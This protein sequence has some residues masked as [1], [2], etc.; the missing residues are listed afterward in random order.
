MKYELFNIRSKN[1]YDRYYPILK[2][3]WEEKEGWR[4]INPEFLSSRGIIVKDNND[5]VCAA[6]LYKTD[7]AYGVIN[8]VITNDKIK[9]KQKKECLKYMFNILEKYAK[10]IKISAIYM[11]METGSLKNFLQKEGFLKT[12]DNIAEFFKYI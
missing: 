10:H 3:W 4:S 1:D 7:S 9:A 2:S 6:W 5:Y 8:W 12:S 11:V